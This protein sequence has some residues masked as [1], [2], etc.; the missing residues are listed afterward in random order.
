[1][2]VSSIYLTKLEVQRMLG[3]NAFGMW[4]LARK[5]E[6]F[7]KPD[8]KA[9]RPVNQDSEEVW[10]GTQVYSW[11]AATDEFAHRG[12]LL[13]RPLPQEPAPGR[14]AGY[15]DTPHGPAMDWDTGLGT[16]RILHSTEHEAAT[17]AA[18]ALARSGNKDGIATVCALFGDVGFRGPALVAADTAHPAI[19]Y[20][21]SWG[22]V[23]ELV[24]QVLPWWPGLLRQSTLIRE[25]RPGAAPTEVEVLANDDE[26]ILRRTAANPN[27]D[28]T[29][30]A[31]ATDMANTIRNERTQHA[32]L[33]VRIFCKE[34]YGETPN[35]VVAGAVPDTRR[36]PLPVVEDREL[37]RPGWQKVALRTDSDAVA[38]LEIALGR[39]PDLLPFG[40]V[41][42]VPVTPGTVSSRWTQRLTMCDPT[43]AHAVLASGAK[44]EA[45]L[46]DPLTDMPVLRTTA[47][48]GTPVL[49]FYA[50]LSLPGGAE[51]TKI[52]LH[53]TVWVVTSDGHTHPAPCAPTEHLWWGDGWGDRPSEAA[54]VVNQLL[55]RLDTTL[56][57]DEHWKAPKGLIDLFNENHD[58][59][60]ELSRATLLQARMTPPRAR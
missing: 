6:K 49:R 24:G 12:A 15:R 57:L 34:G 9:R 22:D 18:S 38:A 39:E 43:A 60:A 52:V 13:L 29:S 20:E 14:W 47:E 50:P 54:S 55:D 11:A 45:F 59:G 10:A 58:E 21:A 31:A 28:V 42:D 8:Q 35:Q 27:L 36:H 2:A 25:W 51:L 37:M 1:M 16:I 32:A 48:D 44:A 17:E 26:R 56:H 7:P 4:R 53:H 19:E 46:I 41:T 40:A 3:V 30:R 33:E 5:Y 23:G